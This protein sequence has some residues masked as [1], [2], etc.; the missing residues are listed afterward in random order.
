MGTATRSASSPPPTPVTVTPTPGAG[1]PPATASP[2]GTPL[3]PPCSPGFSDVPPDAYYAAAVQH[4]VCAGIL[5][6]YAD[7]TFRPAALVTRAQAAK[8][9]GGAFHLPS[10]APAPPRFADVDPTSVFAAPIAAAAA[11]GLFSGYDCGTRAAEPCDSGHRP[12]FR[13]AVPLTR[14]QL[15]KLALRAAGW[16]APAGDAPFADVPPALP[17]PAAL[18][19]RNVAGGY[20]CG[21]LGEPCDAL[22]RPY[23]RPAAALNRG[24]LAKMS[25]WRR[26]PPRAARRPGGTS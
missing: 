17:G 26:P 5:S 11:A 10:A 22:Q 19:C 1:A 25:P 13:P 16:P 14:G 3:V 18:A 21:A 12:Y 6:G 7:G 4:L 2:P 8:V 15:A 23:F 20:T 9:I 24:Q